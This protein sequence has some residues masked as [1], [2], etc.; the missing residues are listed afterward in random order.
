MN[1]LDDRPLSPMVQSSHLTE[2]MVFTRESLGTR[3]TVHDDNFCC[4][5]FRQ[6]VMS[7]CQMISS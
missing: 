5:M 4:E 2:S 3:A 6:V 1:I 7:I